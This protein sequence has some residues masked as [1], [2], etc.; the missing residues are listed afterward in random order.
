[1]QY[2]TMVR[3]R[4]MIGRGVPRALKARV[5]EHRTTRSKVDSVKAPDAAHDFW[6]QTNAGARSQ[7]DF[8]LK[9]LVV[10]NMGRPPL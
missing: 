9:L 2:S 7:S 4:E 10:R 5:G 6:L 8:W 3:T 1:M